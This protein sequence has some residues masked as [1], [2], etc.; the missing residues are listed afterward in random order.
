MNTAF[1][2]PRCDCVTKL[3]SEMEA[4]RDGGRRRRRRCGGEETKR[5]EEERELLRERDGWREFGERSK[6]KPKLHGRLQVG[7]TNGPPAISVT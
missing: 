3:L 1:V 7:L 6:I 2:A 4:E 5:E